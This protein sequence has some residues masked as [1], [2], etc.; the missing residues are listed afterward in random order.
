MS[1][2]YHMYKLCVPPPP[3]PRGSCAT[4]Q[5]ERVRQQVHLSKTASTP[6]LGGSGG[7]ADDVKLLELLGEGSF[8]RVHRGTWRGT[9]VSC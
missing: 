5:I 1:A 7:E 2:L 4:D 8:G 6:H 9:E 3:S